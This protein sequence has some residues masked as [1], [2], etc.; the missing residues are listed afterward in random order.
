MP[1]HHVTMADLRL[2]VGF[3]DINT[4]IGHRQLC[5]LGH[6]ARKPEQ[7][8]ERMA[9]WCWLKPDHSLNAI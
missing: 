7:S 4:M 8:M 1:D 3:L 5:H 9:L 6:L 2:K